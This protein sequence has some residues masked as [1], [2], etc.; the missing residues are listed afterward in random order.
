MVVVSFVL[1]SRPQTAWKGHWKTSGNRPQR[2]MTT[3]P[4]NQF[5]QID[6]ARLVLLNLHIAKLNKRVSDLL[7]GGNLLNL[8]LL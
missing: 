1:Y 6:L 8:Y 4:R 2:E 7:L 3:K 5:A